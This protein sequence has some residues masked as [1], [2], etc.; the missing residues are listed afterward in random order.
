MWIDTKDVERLKQVVD[1]RDLVER[2]GV[3][4]TQR[5]RSWIGR[6]PFHE[7]AEQSF[8]IDTRRKIWRCAGCPAGEGQG[9]VVSFVMKRDRITAE[10]AFEKVR[11]LA[12]RGT[13]PRAATPVRGDPSAQAR[14]LILLG[15][16]AEFYRQRFKLKTEACDYLASRG[17][18]SAETLKVFCAGYS[19][20]SLRTAFEESGQIYEDL[21]ALGLLTEQGE[22]FQG[23]VVFPLWDL[24]GRCVG[25]Y[26]RRL[27]DGEPHVHFPSPARG[28]INWQAVARSDNAVVCRSVLDA[29]SL[30]QAGVSAAL[31]LYGLG[32]FT[33]DHAALLDRYPPQSLTLCF[34]T[35]EADRRGAAELEARLR[36]RFTIRSLAL[37][38]GCDANDVLTERGEEELRRLVLGL[39]ARMSQP[40]ASEAV[41]ANGYGFTLERGDR[42]YEVRGLVPQGL[43]LH[44]TIK[45]WKQGAAEEEFELTTLDLH[46][47]RSRHWFAMQLATL[48]GVDDNVVRLDLNA[49]V[50]KAEEEVDEPVVEQR[51]EIPAREREEA[52][53]LLR[54]P[55][56]LDA[57]AD[58]YDALGFTGERTN[59]LVGYLVGVSRKLDAPLSLLVQSRSGAGKSALQDAILAFVPP[60][61]F[62]KYSRVTDQ[63]LFYNREDA[64][65]HKLLAIEETAGMTGAAYS[66]RA[67][68]SSSNLRIASTGKDPVTG[69]M[70]T[71]EHEVRGPV[72]VL[73]TTTQ[74]DFDQETLSRFLCVTVDESAEMTRRILEAQR[75]SE[76]IEGI[77]RKRRGERTCQRHHDAQRLLES[78]VVANPFAPRLG[79][80]TERLSARR[81][82]RKYLAL[83][84]AVTLLYQHQ[85]DKKRATLDGE[86]IVYIETTID[87]IA[88]ANA[89]AAQVLGQSNSDLTPQGRRLLGLIRRMLTNGH[90][91]Q[92]GR[93]GV[94]S[95]TRRQVREYTGWNDWQVRT[96]LAE[97]VA[98]EHLHVRAGKR[99]KE[100][101]YELGDDAD[102]IQA[103]PAFGLTDPAALASTLDPS[104]VGSRHFEEVRG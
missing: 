41:T 1:L 34:G 81:D 9:D 13:E 46:S 65:E 73:L 16:V 45:A 75:E 47:G 49:L 64:L 15:R 92:V 68:Q 28:L 82:H 58:D 87:D 50:K 29:L 22:L 99:G 4:L 19:D 90:A 23:C 8:V 39:P 38:D 2:S 89:L 80:P 7:D 33:D 27:G 5:G 44:A 88:R 10:A 94:G 62:L 35:G 14:R 20:G 103:H 83:I 37:P 48:F 54:Q 6:C 30:H 60:E 59:K 55:N 26:G 3:Q 67:I 42:R 102:A 78:L 97:L 43:K 74:T 72:A 63:A 77:L 31:A 12:T 18:T 36:E 69:R 91:D 21:V 85:R 57:I 93:D 100:Y 32:G 84:K 25:M 52:L 56:L 86:E 104:L 11:E 98:L 66:I 70:R 101:V 51:I 17:I 53:E 95:V 79:F 71:D 76:T 61:D 24:A 96:H 40:A